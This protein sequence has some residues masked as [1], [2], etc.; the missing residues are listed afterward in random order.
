MKRLATTERI[1]EGSVLRVY[2][3]GYGYSKLQV[4]DITTHYLATSADKEFHHHVKDGE[5]LECYLWI[6]NVASYEFK[7]VVRGRISQGEPIIFLSHSEDIVRSE[8]RKCLT[9]K[10]SIPLK[11]FIFSSRETEKRFKSEEIVYH[12]GT[13][14]ELSDREFL[15]ENSEVLSQGSFLCGHIPLNEE[16]LEIVGKIESIEDGKGA[17]IFTGM[18]D[19][20]RTLLLDYIFS[21][22]RE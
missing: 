2:L 10:V 13:I 18:N 9:A 17:I 20:D 5:T 15:L 1:P 21:I 22:Y 16:S 6:E 4:F 12:H 11:F 7:V 8:K 19:R 14:T 3:P